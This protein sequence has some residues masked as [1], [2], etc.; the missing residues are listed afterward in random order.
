MV[1][2]C[3]LTS[4][5]RNKTKMSILETFIQHCIG[6]YSHSNLARKTNKSPNWKRRRKTVTGCR[7]HGTLHRKILRCFKK[8]FVIVFKSLSRAWLFV[9]Q[10]TAECQA[11][12]SFSISWSLFKLMPIKSK[13]PSSHLILCCPLLLPSILP[14]IRV[15]SYESAL[16][17]RWPNYWSFSFSPS[18]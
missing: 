9:T 8:Y 10:W 4:K 7:W 16:C 18:N 13:L 15:F 3:G 14:N 12:L 5:I 17:I 11:S 1:K 2:C 6:S